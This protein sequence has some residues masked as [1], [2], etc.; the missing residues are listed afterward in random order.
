M[1]VYV[2]DMFKTRT[3]R[4][5]GMKMSH[6]CASGGEPELRAFADC[7]GLKP[8]WIQHPG[9]DRV[10]FDIGLNL[11]KRAIALG[12]VPVTQRKL[13]ELRI[14]WRKQREALVDQRTR[15]RPDGSRF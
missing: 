5:R 3:G 12:A 13:A 7:L 2:D 8:S 10:H 1:T 14:E 11:R 9:T 15:M 4:F 6:L